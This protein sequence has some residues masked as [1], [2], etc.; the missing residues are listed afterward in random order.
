[1]QDITEQFNERLIR[2][3]PMKQAT[4]MKITKLLESQ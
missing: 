3:K 2:L 4:N 1:M